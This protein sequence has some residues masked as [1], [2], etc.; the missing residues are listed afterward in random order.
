MTVASNLSLLNQSSKF[1]RGGVNTS[2]CRLKPGTVFI[3]PAVAITTATDG[4]E[5]IDSHAAFRLIILGHNCERVSCEKVSRR[6]VETMKT[7]DLIGTRATEIE[8]ALAKKK[9]R[10]IRSAKKVLFCNS[11]SE[12][13]HNAVRLARAATGRRNAAGDVLKDQRFC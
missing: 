5:Y 12:A 7:I 8:I 4:K 10:H 6:V 11:G 9:C 1:T 2:L 13:T 3:R